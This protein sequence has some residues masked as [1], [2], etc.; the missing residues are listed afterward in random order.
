MNP[1]IHTDMKTKRFLTLAAVLYSLTATSC[2]KENITELSF[3]VSVTN[4]VTGC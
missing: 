2:Q 3:Q 1:Y 4:T